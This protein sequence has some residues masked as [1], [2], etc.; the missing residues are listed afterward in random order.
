LCRGKYLL[1]AGVY[2]NSV[3]STSAYAA[4]GYQPWTLSG[5]KIGALVGAVSGYEKP[6]AGGLF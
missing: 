1:G 5:L 3:G 6:G 4:A 2:R